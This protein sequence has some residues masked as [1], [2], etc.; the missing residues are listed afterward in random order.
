VLLL[1]ILSKEEICT[2]SVLSSNR[3]Q[4][5]GALRHAVTAAEPALPELAAGGVAMAAAGWA[6]SRRPRVPGKKNFKIIFPLQR[7]CGQLDVKH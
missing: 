6:M 2:A 4:S 7:K 3:R 5:S 1:I